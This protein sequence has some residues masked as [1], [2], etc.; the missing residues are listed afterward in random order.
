M[1]SAPTANDNGS[2]GQP[3]TALVTAMFDRKVLCGGIAGV[4]SSLDSLTLDGPALAQSTG[5]M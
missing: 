4:A 2:S 3:N 5:Q 1:G